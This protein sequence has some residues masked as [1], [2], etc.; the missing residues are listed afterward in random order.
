MRGNFTPFISKSVQIWD[1]LFPILFPNDSKNLTILDIGLWKVGSKR[2]MNGVNKWKNSCTN[3]F[4]RDDFT[5]FNEQKFSNLRQLLSLTFPQE[6]QKSKKF[7]H[8]NSKSG[9]KK[10]VIKVNIT[11]TKKI[12]LS[13]AKFAQK[14]TF[15]ARRFYTLL[16]VK[17]FKS[18]IT[19]CHYFS[20]RIPNL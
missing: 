7:G 2:G 12:L 16:L 19:S 5:S 4:C 11:N 20:P 18:E 1:H 9:G 15:F 13:M 14:Q 10:T 17:V 6:F 3:F 8:W